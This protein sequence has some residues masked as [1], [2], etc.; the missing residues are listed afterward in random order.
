MTN[1]AQEMRKLLAAV[2]FSN[3]PGGLL[4]GYRS[5]KPILFLMHFNS[6]WRIEIFNL[7][8]IAFGHAEKSF[9]AS[10]KNYKIIAKIIK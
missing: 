3:N 2:P 1:R 6:V 10:L 7:L 4:H 9:S 5:V 8:L